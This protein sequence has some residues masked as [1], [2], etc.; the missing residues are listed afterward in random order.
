MAAGCEAT[1]QDWREHY[2]VTRHVEL[3]EDV[4]YGSAMETE[5]KAAYAELNCRDAVWSVSIQ[6][7]KYGPRVPEYK[8]LNHPV[9]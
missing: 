4:T 8:L 7:V 9:L 1:C 2:I 3:L 5:Q 6:Q